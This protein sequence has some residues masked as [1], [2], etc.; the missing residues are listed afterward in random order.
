MTIRGISR[1]KYQPNIVKRTVR[2]TLQATIAGLP[3]DVRILKSV[4][5]WSVISEMELATLTE[6]AVGVVMSR[7]K[8]EWTIKRRS[9]PTGIFLVKFTASYTVGDPESTKT[10]ASFNYGF[11]EVMPAPVRAVIDG[12]SS[13]RWGSVGIATVDGSLSYD[14]DIGPGNR[15]GLSFIWSCL[16]PEENDSVS[17]DCFGS[18]YGV[19]VVNFIPTSI[20]IDPGQLEINKTYILRLNVTKGERSSLAEISFEIASGDIPQVALR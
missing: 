17:N 11:I 2:S 5:E 19:P 1:D 9:V 8:T 10:L 6:T 3:G 20:I 7:G 12:G 16:D 15:T 4:L 14:E 18:F 13:V